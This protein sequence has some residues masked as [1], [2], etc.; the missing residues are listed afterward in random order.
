ML[1]L[2]LVAVNKSREALESS[3]YQKKEESVLITEN[4]LPDIFYLEKQCSAPGNAVI[5]ETISLISYS[6]SGRIHYSI[7]DDGPVKEYTDFYFFSR[8]PPVIN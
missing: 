2:G 8:P 4:N 1:Y 3:D 5:K 7:Y 6:S